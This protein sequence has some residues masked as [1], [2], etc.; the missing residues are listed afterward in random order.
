[1]ALG[2]QEQRVKRK[3]GEE[4]VLG[5]SRVCRLAILEERCKELGLKVIYDDLRGEGGMCRLR[6]EYLVIINR[7]AA[8][9]TK[10]RILE[11]ALKRYEAKTTVIPPLRT[12]MSSSHPGSG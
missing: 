3:K 9:H 5:E 12:A 11:Q 4:R 6:N 7:R 10:I 2:E 1:M 8:V